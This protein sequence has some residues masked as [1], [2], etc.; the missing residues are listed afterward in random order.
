MDPPP[1]QTLF[2]TKSF[3][4]NARAT[5]EVKIPPLVEEV[6]AAVVR[7]SDVDPARPVGLG[8]VAADLLEA[9]NDPPGQRACH[10]PGA[11]YAERQGGQFLAATERYV[12]LASRLYLVTG[13]ER[14]YLAGRY[15]RADKSGGFFLARTGRLLLVCLHQV[16]ASPGDALHVMRGMQKTLV[17]EGF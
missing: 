2:V 3:L 10:P 9:S 14:G 15:A 6:P 5:A 7:E 11:R 17:A 8:L 4:Q 12:T 16:P 13:V 1:V